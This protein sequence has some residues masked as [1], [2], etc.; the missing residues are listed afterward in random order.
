M[1]A[2]QSHAP[3]LSA[4]VLSEFMRRIWLGL[5]KFRVIS[6]HAFVAS[7]RTHQVLLYSAGAPVFHRRN[8]IR[9]EKRQRYGEFSASFKRAAPSVATA[10]RVRAVRWVNG[11]RAT[12]DCFT[13]ASLERGLNPSPSCL[14]D[15]RG[16]EGTRVDGNERNRAT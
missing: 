11:L 7:I 10:R 6:M 16:I 3:K 2:T 14:H 4:I 15:G 1:A 12:A 9:R 5:K 13:S 8:M